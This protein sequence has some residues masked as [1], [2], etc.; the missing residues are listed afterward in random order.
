[1]ID[2]RYLVIVL[3]AAGCFKAAGLVEA[4]EPGPE[5]GPNAPAPASNLNLSAPIDRWDEAV[6]L[7]NGLMGG[8]LWGGGQTVRLSLDRGD[9]WDLRTPDTLLRKDWTYATIRKLVGLKDQAQLVKLFDDPYGVAYPTKIPAGRL[10]LTLDKSQ[11]VESFSLDLLNAVGRAKATGGLVEVFFSADQ[12][13]AMIRVPS[14]QV[15]WKIIAPAC[16]K[17]L[18]YPEAKQGREGET[19]WFVQD[20]ALGLRFAVVVSSRRT[21]EATLLAL[22]VTS[23]KDGGDPLALGSQRVS[24]ALEAGY[25]KMLKAHA[26][27]WARFWS[28]S[29]VELPD[30]AIQQHYDLVQYFYGAGSRRGR[31]P[32]PLQGVWTADEG[33]L[34]PWKGD[35]HNDLNTQLTYWAYLS[36]GHF[37]EGMSFLDFLFNLLPAHEK[38]ARDFYGAPGAG[39]PGV[40]TLDGKPTGGWGQYS[41]SPTMGAWIAHSFYLHWRYTLDKKFLAQQAYPYCAAIG[42]CLQALLRPGENGRLK[43]P[44]ST[45]PEIHDNS[46]AAWLAPNTNFDLALLRWLYGA[47]AE[48]AEACGDAPAAQ[49]WK[50]VLGRL[51][52]LAVETAGPKNGPDVGPLML[53]PNESLRE[54]HRHHSH[55]MAIHPLGIL[56]VEGTDRDRKVIAASLQQIDKLGTNAWCGYSFSWMACIAARSGDADRA[57]KNLEVYA[58]AFVSRNGFH[59]N[60]DYKNLGYSG[61]K[62]RP[63]TMEGNFAAGQAVHEMLLQSWGGVIRLFPAVPQA[64]KD[65]YF[66]SL[67]GEGAFRVSGRRRGGRTVWFRVMAEREGLVRV[68]DPFGGEEATWNRPGVKRVDQNWEFQLR[69]GEL[70]EARLGIH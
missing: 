39:V 19:C 7:G 60:G 14:P 31:A 20:C 43:L 5:S 3:A 48:M 4:D 55:L 26:K 15:Q 57:L 45:S 24:A 46:L 67:R 18:G 56:N 52:D 50:G 36:A 63:F 16:V 53:S 13:V 61:F 17:Q 38:F 8:L 10:E 37:D 69:P 64:W 51:D 59:L 27:W 6:P 47:L 65:V 11:T 22:T 58:K 41:L 42:E 21:D 25:D 9:L 1:M 30:A 29:R 34:P 23:N 35:Y 62:Y 49:R 40:M 44:L 33:G 32:I 54:S 12:P 68:R 70:L 28:P 2:P 66:D